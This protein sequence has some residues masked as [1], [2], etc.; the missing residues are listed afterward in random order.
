MANMDSSLV[1]VTEKLEVRL[2]G[3]FTQ[4]EFF[5]LN[6]SN[7]LLGVDWLNANKAYI[8][9]FDKALVFGEREIQ[10]NSSEN[11]GDNVEVDLL[12]IN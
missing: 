6:R 11:Y 4:M 9:T 1:E 2:H 7:V 12:T 10:L 5:V 8:R 3:T